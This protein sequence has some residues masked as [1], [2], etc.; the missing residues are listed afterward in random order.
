MNVGDSIITVDNGEGT[1]TRTIYDEH[2]NVTSV[3]QL[4]GF[5]V[6]PI[7]A[8]ILPADPDLTP[9]SSSSRSQS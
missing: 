7:P 6:A 9:P 4:T 3:E 5:P 2:G 8:R 1:G